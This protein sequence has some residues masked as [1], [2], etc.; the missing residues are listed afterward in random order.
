MKVEITI[1]RQKNCRMALCL[2]WRRSYCGDWIKTLITA[3]LWFVGPALIGWPCLVEWTEIKTCRGNPAGHQGKRWWL[4]LLSW[5]PVACLVYFEDFAVSKNK[6]C[7]TPAM[8]LS[9]AMMGWSLLVWHPFLCVSALWC[10][11]AATLFRLC[12]CSRMRSWGLS[13]FFTDDWKG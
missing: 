2:L 7:R 1:D 9:D 12:L 6:K 5:G 8:Q 4:V 10:T 13:L 11:G 3:V